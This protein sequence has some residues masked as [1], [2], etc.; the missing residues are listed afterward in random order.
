MIVA[1]ADAQTQIAD[2]A[3][4]GREDILNRMV[5]GSSAV[6]A[7]RLSRIN[8]WGRGRTVGIPPSFLE[9]QYDLCLVSARFGQDFGWLQRKGV[10]IADHRLPVNKY[11]ANVSG[12]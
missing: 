2:N 1:C 6:L 12:F 8:V 11:I 4:R 9:G 5:R 7:L 3:A 10:A